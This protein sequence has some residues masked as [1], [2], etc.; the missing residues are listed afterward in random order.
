MFQTRFSNSARVLPLLGI[1]VFAGASHLGS[2]LSA[3]LRPQAAVAQEQPVRIAAREGRVATSGRATAPVLSKLAQDRIKPVPGAAAGSFEEMS[4][5]IT[6]AQWN[7]LSVDQRGMVRDMLLK[8]RAGKPVPHYC[9]RPG[10]PASQMRTIDAVSHALDFKPNFQPYFGRWSSTATNPTVA[11]NQPFTLTWNLT[12]DSDKSDIRAWA[13]AKYGS[14][15]EFRK[16]VRAMFALWSTFIPITYVEV[17]YDD[18]ADANGQLGARPDI[19]ISGAELTGGAVGVNSNPNFGDMTIHTKTDYFDTDKD[20]RGERLFNMMTHEHGHGIGL[21]HSCPQNQTK[22]M[23]PAVNE[24]FHGPQFDD[25]LS[26]QFLYGDAYEKGTRNNTPRTATDLGIM[27][28]GNETVLKNVSLNI[29][30]VDLY[31]I[32]PDTNQRSVTA[33]LKPAG[34]KYLEGPTVDGGCVPEKAPVTEFNPTNQRNLTLEIVNDTG[35][36]LA[37]SAATAAGGEESIVNFD[38]TGSG[39]YYARVSSPDTQD[40]IQAYELSLK[41]GPRN[42]QPPVISFFRFNP[43]RPDTDDVLKVEFG[44]DD[45]EKDAVT[46]T[47]T[48]KRNGQV[49]DVTNDT[50]DLSIDGNGDDGDEFEVTLVATDSAGSSTTATIKVIIRPPNEKPDLADA[51]FT[52]KENKVLEAT[53]VATDPNSDDPNAEEPLTY[54]LVNRPA[55]GTVILSPNGEFT[56]TPKLNFNGDDSFIVEVSDLD[57]LKDQAT[58]NVAVTPVNNAPEPKDD[59]ISTKEDVA[60]TIQAA[61]LLKND[62]NGEIEGETDEMKII[63]VK[64]AKGF[65]GTVQLDKELQ[66]IVFTPKLNWNGETSFTYTVEDSAKKRGTATVT[67]TVLPVN[68]APV[69][70]DLKVD[71]FSGTAVEIQL[72]GS[73]PEGDL[74]S[75]GFKNKPANGKVSLSQRDGKWYVLYTPAKDFVGTDTMTYVAK[76][77]FLTSAPATIQIKVA[78]NTPPKI[79]SLTPKSGIFPAES[80][81]V[82]TQQVRDTN[83]I[84]HLNAVSLLIS[85]STT[86]TNTKKGAALWY[87]VVNNEFTM[88]TD[89]GKTTYTPLA[90]G[91]KL[92]N[93]QVSVELRQQDITRD[94]NGTLTLKWRVTFKLGFV[95]KKTL[96]SYVQD[97]GGATAGYTA[98]GSIEIGSSDK[99]SA[100]ASSANNS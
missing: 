50:I 42:N 97:L 99:P 33:V 55:N 56:Y 71:T 24:N 16:R 69:A 30:D 65:P 23:E 45:A 7:D 13:K 59:T 78:K 48:W 82:F 32:T 61:K 87:D 83:G 8:A 1:A 29:N 96:W 46:P 85:D 9:F 21:S 57:G 4:R 44:Y 10:T 91:Q 54:K 73:D 41:I 11:R 76:D 47:T 53:L 77:G 81:V 14:E 36:V 80:T 39:P 90:V 58:I 37:S 3:K 95:G 38:L 72:I 26:A 17:D 51:Q 92:Y 100:T 19:R 84:R 6:R 66:T 89:D 70:K 20:L 52:T 86:N 18:G 74:A 67:L 98:Q 25:I 27:P 31:K 22:V 63:S 5:L 40:K 88:S 75:F 15:E 12:P 94:S 62:S 64:V 68:D 93:S 79:V 49:I 2:N 34:A 35:F 60:L 28:I 43:P